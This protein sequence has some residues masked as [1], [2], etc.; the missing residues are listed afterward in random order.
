M[1]FTIGSAYCELLSWKR[2]MHFVNFLGNLPNTQVRTT[3]VFCQWVFQV[4]LLENGV[5]QLTDP[6]AT[7]AIFPQKNRAHLYE[8]HLLSDVSIFPTYS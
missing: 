8:A 2:Q 4:K 6:A 1:N 5:A 3:L 7:V